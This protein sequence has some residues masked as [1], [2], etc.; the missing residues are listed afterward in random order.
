MMNKHLRSMGSQSQVEQ[1]RQQ[2]RHR[3]HPPMTPR[4]PGTPRATTV[5]TLPAVSER[6]GSRWSTAVR[7][8][9]TAAAFRPAAS[10]ASRLS[11]FPA[12]GLRN[13]FPSP[14]FT[15]AQRSGTPRVPRAVSRIVNH[16]VLPK[17]PPRPI[18][19]YRM[20]TESALNRARSRCQP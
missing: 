4:P 5:P 2:H 7:R 12:D 1:P 15:P 3:P 18:H 14:V 13:E 16:F 19:A 10:Y 6:P 11:V 8:A 9:T 20:P 17:L